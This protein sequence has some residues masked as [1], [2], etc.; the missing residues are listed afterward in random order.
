MLQVWSSLLGWAFPNVAVNEY[1]FAEL[2]KDPY[3]HTLILIC[4]KNNVQNTYV[5]TMPIN[6]DLDNGAL[7]QVDE[8]GISA[9][10][11]FALTS[12]ESDLFIEDEPSA[13]GRCEGKFIVNLPWCS[14]FLFKKGLDL[15][16][17]INFSFH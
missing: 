8:K 7:A 15:S 13:S 2:P 10:D 11:M 5:E 4:L 6:L 3:A 16:K 9:E 1:C 17:S 14:Y 12:Y